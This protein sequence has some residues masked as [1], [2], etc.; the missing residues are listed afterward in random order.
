MSPKEAES[1]MGKI[2]NTTLVGIMVENLEALHPE[3]P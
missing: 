2:M 3:N 1:Q